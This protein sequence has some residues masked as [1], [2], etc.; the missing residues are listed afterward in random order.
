S[1][2]T[3]LI[4]KQNSKGRADVIIETDNDVF[5]FEFKLDGSAEEALAQ[6][7]EKQYAVPYL[8]DKRK[9]HKIGVNILSESRTVNQ[10][11][12]TE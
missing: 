4:E 9:V 3:T 11:L 12:V 2:Y 8:D 7:E 5:I 10:W 6:I 1:C